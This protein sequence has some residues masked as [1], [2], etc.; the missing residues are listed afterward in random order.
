MASADVYTTDE[1]VP[2]VVA[3][4]GGVLQNDS[5]GDGDALTA[6]LVSD[7]TSGVL[8]LNPDG[9]FSYTP[10]QDFAGSDSFSYRAAGGGGRQL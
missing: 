6:V 1:D 3:A 9:S 8:T 4:A 7:V 10:N 5:D 2:L